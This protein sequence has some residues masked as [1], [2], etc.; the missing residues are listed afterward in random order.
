[1]K[2]TRMTEAAITRKLRGGCQ[3]AEVIPDGSGRSAYVR[4]DDGLL[5]QCSMKDAMKAM[6]N[7]AADAPEA[8]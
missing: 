2:F 1:M 6:K 7:E 8:A 4:F 3:I 5:A